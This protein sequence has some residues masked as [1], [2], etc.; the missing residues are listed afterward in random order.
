MTAHDRRADSLSFQ[1]SFPKPGGRGRDA[2]GERTKTALRAPQASVVG[3]QCS[4]GGRLRRGTG[5]S[6]ANTRQGR[7]P[8]ATRRATRGSS[9]LGGDPAGQASSCPLTASQEQGQDRQ[10]WLGAQCGLH[11][12]SYS[13]LLTSWPGDLRT[14]SSAGAPSS[15][16]PQAMDTPHGFTPGIQLP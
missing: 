13:S 8:V 15:T 9:G 4:A 10:G 14:Y 1:S 11:S 5:P 2:C 16:Y 3:E 6:Q 7:P 12:C